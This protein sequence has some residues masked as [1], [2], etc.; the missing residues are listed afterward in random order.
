MFLKNR[1][2]II[3]KGMLLLIENTLIDG[4]RINLKGTGGFISIL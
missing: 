3:V 1:W 4:L 2:R